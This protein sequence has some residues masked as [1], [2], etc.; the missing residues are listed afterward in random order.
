M[1][2]HLLVNKTSLDKHSLVV[3][4]FLK[5][6]SELSNRFVKIAH[7]SKHKARVEF[8]ACKP[9][10]AFQRVAE[11][12]K[13]LNDQHFLNSRV[14]RIFSFGLKRKAFGMVVFSF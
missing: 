4:K 5:D 12:L 11:A 13:R 14:F 7:A 8:R 6:S 9:V 2:A 1:I 3:P 10:V